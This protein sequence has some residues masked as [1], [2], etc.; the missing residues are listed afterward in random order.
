MGNRKRKFADDGWALW[1][2]GDDR[3]TIYLNEWINPKGRSYVDISVRVYGAKETKTVNIF[4]PFAIESC[5]IVDLSYM[6]AD[7]SALRALFNTNGKVDSQKTKYTSELRYD[8]RTVSL[9]NLTNEGMEVK[10]VSYG[11]VITANFEFIKD[12]IT[13]DEAYL[14][15]RIPHKTLDKVFASKVDVGSMFERIN[16]LIQSPIISEKYGYS[17][18]I[19]E[20]RLLP[21]EINEIKDLHEQ[22]IRKALV[23]ISIGDEYEM[24]DST[25][26][27]IRR[28]EAELNRN[29]A[30]EGYD[31]SSAITYQ[32]VE[33]RDS[34]MKAHYNFY[35]TMEHNEISKFSMFIYLFM[36]LLIGALGGAIYDLFKLMFGFM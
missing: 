30:P 7:S 13:S 2:D 4:V 16:S 15:F 12:Y 11:T 31:C 34:N 28:L 35:F 24:N 6:L 19:N 27:R 21:P 25:C 26:Y 18:R 32:W 36:V 29:Y 17:I 1:I 5:E 9:I 14:I 8:N 33:E 23:T 10:K 22:R 20:A 3:S